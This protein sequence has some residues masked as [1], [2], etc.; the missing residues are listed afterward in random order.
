MEAKNI[1]SLNTAVYVMRHFVELSAKLLPMY[2][3]ITRNEP[4]SIYSESDKKRIDVIYE[5][6]NINPKTSEFLLGS[7]IIDLIKKT[8]SELKNRSHN[9]EKTAQEQLEAFQ[10]E[11]ERLKQDWYVTLMN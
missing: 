3:R 10:E 2:E 5:T 11:Y 6:Y 7:D 1:R 4:H 9:N 8:Y